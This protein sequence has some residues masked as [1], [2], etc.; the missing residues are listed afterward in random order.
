MPIP[1]HLHDDLHE[2]YESGNL[3]LFAGAGISAAARLPDWKTLA[4]R[5][6][7]RL[8]VAGAAAHVTAEIDELIQK[9]RLVDALSAVKQ[10]LH[11]NEFNLAVERA[12][13]DRALPVPDVAIA[14][15]E[16]KPKLRAVLTTNLDHFLERAFQGEW[17]AQTT[18]SGNMTQRRAYIWKLHGT[19]LDRSS[20]VFTRNQYDQSMFASPLYR[21]T[22]EAIFR[23]LQVLFVGCGLA[24]DDLDLTLGAVRALMG[25]QP[26]EHFA[27]IKG[28]IAPYRRTSL[29]NAGLR[30]IEYDAHSDVPLLL[31]SIR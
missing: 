28:P 3:V 26:P 9:G 6:L 22:F 29:E 1:P 16:L 23:T 17:P 12:L 25:S 11:T 20:W 15:A 7:D 18:P 13:S 8:R 10:E 5:L 24:D 4:L 2:A 21:S 14:I 27:L 31:R 19:L 30:I